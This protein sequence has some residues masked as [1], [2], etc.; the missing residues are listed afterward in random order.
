MEKA[1]ITE[2]PIEEILAGELKR[3]K[4][5]FVTQKQIGRYRVDFFFP[6][7]NLIVETDG[8]KWHGTEEQIAYDLKR[9]T[10][11]RKKHQLYRFRGTQ[12]YRDIET[13]GE[14]IE[15]LTYQDK[16]KDIL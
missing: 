16:I 2:S 13:V 8:K 14:K 12:I 9:A 10:E 3:R 15:M 11:I 6:E 7:S 5:N 4:I 1:K